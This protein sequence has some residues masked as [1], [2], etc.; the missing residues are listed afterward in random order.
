MRIKNFIIAMLLAGMVLVP[1]IKLFGAERQWGSVECFQFLST[2]EVRSKKAD[3]KFYL[4][5]RTAAGDLAS[6]GMNIPTGDSYQINNVNVIDA[7]SLGSTVVSSSLTSHGNQT[8]KSFV[9]LVEIAL[10]SSQP[11]VLTTTSGGTDNRWKTLQFDADGGATGDNHT[12]F[13]WHCPD[14]YVTDSL[15][16]NFIWSCESA[17]T[18][19]VTVTL[20]LAVLSV[21][22]GEAVDAAM[23]GITA[24]ADT[25]WEGN[26]D[27]VYTTQLNPE[28]VD[29]VVDDTVYFDFFIDESGSTFTDT[30]DLHYIEPEW[31]STE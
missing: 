6:D 11:P 2:P 10:A 24:V 12:F 16:L 28:V 9:P 19:G 27:R 20:D 23:T 8:R 18:S 5:S 3:L 25:Q 31:E 13:K 22:S 17:E 29:I 26:A 7:T 15:R 14:G 21:A 30:W 4:G 1:T